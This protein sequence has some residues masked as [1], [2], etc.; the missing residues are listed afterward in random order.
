MGWIYRY[1]TYG[2][3][4]SLSVL[5]FLLLSG[6]VTV[7][8]AVAMKALVVKPVA[9]LTADDQ[10]VPLACPSAV[11]FDKTSEEIYVINSGKGRIVVYGLDFFPRI[12]LG[13]GRGVD[14]P[15]GGYINGDGRL[16]VC[17]GRR[18]DKPT[19]LTILNAAFFP[20]K[21]NKF[22]GFEGADTFIPRR[23]ALGHDG[24]IYLAGINTHGVIVLDSEGNYL[25]HLT[26]MDRVWIDE[27]KSGQGSETV[28]KKGPGKGPVLI[29]E[30]CTDKAG[31]IY[32]LS[33]ETSKIYVYDQNE[34]FL[35]SFGKK[36]GSSGK[37]SR[38]RGLAVDEDRGRIYVVDYLRH[39]ILVYNLSGRY[40]FEFG[41][42]GWGPGWFN[43]PTSSAIDNQG[44]LIVADFFNNR[45][46]ILEV[47]DFTELLPKAEDSN[48][49]KPEESSLRDVESVPNFLAVPPSK[50]S[51]SR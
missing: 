32:L 24:K 49:T 51:R 2:R 18:E 14:A 19:R 3:L 29:L 16:Y 21:E 4:F 5:L 1:N 43:F 7:R 17:Q 37:L 27:D 13:A 42:R 25:R 46:Q 34:N 22:E 50:K 40:L 26:P 20:I 48:A 23:V 10:G 30:V 33:E 12:S 8:V 28:S 6:L 31:R 45:V 38:P 35:F 47:P 15:Y 41:G 36:G 9:M 44:H 39:T 11:F